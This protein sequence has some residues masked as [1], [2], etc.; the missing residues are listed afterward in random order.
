MLSLMKGEPLLGSRSAFKQGHEGLA[1][2]D[3]FKCT[4][5]PCVYI[6]WLNET[7][8]TVTTSNQDN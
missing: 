1:G 7:T 3:A 6:Q 4:V 8:T 5:Q 2:L